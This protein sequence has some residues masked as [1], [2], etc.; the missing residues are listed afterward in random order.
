MLPEDCRFEFENEVYDDG[1]FGVVTVR[2]DENGRYVNAG[3]SW[4]VYTVDPG[5]AQPFTLVSE[6]DI[7]DS[8]R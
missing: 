1:S 3:L 4:R 8:T 6:S 5:A 2:P 7:K